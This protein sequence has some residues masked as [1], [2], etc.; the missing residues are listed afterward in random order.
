MQ[1]SHVDRNMD[2]WTIR[3][4]PNEIHNEIKR[5]AKQQRRTINQEYLEVLET[6]HSLRKKGVIN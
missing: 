2:S 4:I 1:Y 5:A 3:N 6:W